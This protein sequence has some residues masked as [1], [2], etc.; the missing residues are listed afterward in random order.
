MAFSFELAAVARVKVALPVSILAKRWLGVRAGPRHRLPPVP[1][2]REPPGPWSPIQ[3]R[4]PLHPR[5]VIAGPW[6]SHPAPL[7][8]CRPRGRVG[9]CRITRPE[10]S[11]CP[12]HLVPSYRRGPASWDGP[13]RH[14]GHVSQLRKLRPE[15]RGPAQSHCLRPPWAISLCSSQPGDRTH[16]GGPACSQASANSSTS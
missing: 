7:H 5:H 11:T 16:G 2:A 8:L 9:G 15:R 3:R 4:S 10:G 13:G 12:G 14:G 1:V 6:P